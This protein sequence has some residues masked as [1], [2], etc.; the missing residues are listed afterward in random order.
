MQA[1]PHSLR[2]S[3]GPGVLTLSRELRSAEGVGMRSVPQNPPGCPPGGIKPSPLLSGSVQVPF[4][5][6]TRE[7]VSSHEAGNELSIICIS[8]SASADTHPPT[9]RPLFLRRSAPPGLK[10]CQHLPSKTCHVP[11]PGQSPLKAAKN[12]NKNNI[13]SVLLLPIKGKGIRE[14]SQEVSFQGSGCS[15]FGRNAFWLQCI[16]GDE[17]R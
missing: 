14:G 4:P 5:M 1:G 11:S 6:A 12:K 8:L 7:V 10:E 15:H 17:R 9:H 3:P 2:R 13:N 16:S